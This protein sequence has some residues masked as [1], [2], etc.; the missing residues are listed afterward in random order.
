MKLPVFEILIDGESNGQWFWDARLNELR[1]TDD[2]HM[3]ERVDLYIDLAPKL[4]Q[5]AVGGSFN[6]GGGAQPV[7]EYRRIS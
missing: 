6:E 5:T 3:R 1:K 7:F 2:P 4:N